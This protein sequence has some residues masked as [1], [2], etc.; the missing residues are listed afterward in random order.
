[1]PLRCTS[2]Y[3]ETIFSFQLDE[4][5]WISLQHRN[6][7]ERHLRMHCCPSNV[8]LKKSKL[9]T[10]FFAH[11][12]RGECTSAPESPEHLLAKQHVS[13]AVMDAGWVA[14]TEQRGMTPDGDEWI[15]DVLANSGNKNIAF[16]IQWSPQ[17]LEDTITRQQKYKDS[18]VRGLWLFKQTQFPI[19][20]DTPAFRLRLNNETNSFDVLM[21][22]Q[23]YDP[24]FISNKDKE[25]EFYWRQ[26]IPLKEFVV[27]ALLGKL[28]FG[29]SLGIVMKADVYSVKIECWNCK[30]ITKT[31]TSIKFLP[32]ELLKNHPQFTLNIYTS[33]NGVGMSILDNLLPKEFLRISGISEIK[34]RYCDY[35][36]SLL[37]RHFNLDYWHQEKITFT[38]EVTLNSELLNV[39][40][41]A[42]Y[43]WFN[44]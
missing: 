39:I 5:S 4:Q 41:T 29:P 2:I 42:N 7:S 6:K 31:L 19:S 28:C 20:Q 13:E 30:K 10:Q 16:E 9:G 37:E 40:K 14:L 43:W 1:M 23:H 18:K 24:S 26:I 15:A 12:K 27:G 25:S 17:S 32:P 8:V 35:C 33:Y 11:T 3:G 38:R 21:P 34:P 36:A 22:S 44:K